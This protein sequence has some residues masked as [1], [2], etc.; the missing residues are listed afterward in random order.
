[1]TFVSEVETEV[2]AQLDEDAFAAA[3]T[4]GKSTAIQAA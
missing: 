3:Y 1:M 4:E 2:R